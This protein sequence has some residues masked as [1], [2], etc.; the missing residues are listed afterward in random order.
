MAFKH[1]YLFLTVLEAGKYKLKALIDLV[2]GES[3][4]PDSKIAI[5]V[6]C[7]YMLEDRIKKGK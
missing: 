3:P 2:S 4:F 7:P 5:F 1:S 6:L